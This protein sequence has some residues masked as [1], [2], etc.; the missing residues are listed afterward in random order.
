[1]GWSLLKLRGLLSRARRP[2]YFAG[3]KCIAYWATPVSGDGGLAV[4]ALSET[5]L[6]RRGKSPRGFYR[7]PH[8]AASFISNRQSDAVYIGPTSHSV[9]TNQ[10]DLFE[11]HER[12][13]VT[14]W[15]L[16]L[17]SRM[18]DFVEK[19]FSCDA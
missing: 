17:E 18:A 15:L 8:L 14:G 1:M 7:P 3:W 12:H 16:R 11:K 13:H 9:A 4:V 2:T 19:V 5:T 6:P 10:F